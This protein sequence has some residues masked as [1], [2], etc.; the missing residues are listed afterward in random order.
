MKLTIEQVSKLTKLSIPTLRVYVS[1]QKLGTKV[2]NNRFFS[3]ADVQ[4][5]LKGS[6]RAGGKAEAKTATKAPSKKAKVA[7]P[8]KAAKAAKAAPRPKPAAAKP[9]PQKAA[10]PK[11]EK[12]ELKT[13]PVRSSFWSRLF[14]SRGPKPKIN[15]LEA[16]STK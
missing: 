12:P 13:K 7:K 16:K 3:Q 8:A 2:G 14:G 11:A 15:V 5:L 1:R 6:R 10:A 4:K 9:A